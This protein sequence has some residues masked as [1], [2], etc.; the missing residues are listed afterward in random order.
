MASTMHDMLQLKGMH[1]LMLVLVSL[2]LAMSKFVNS[3]WRS[4][5]SKSD[6]AIIPLVLR[7]PKR[8]TV[9]MF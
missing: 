8:M 3:E 7:C 5:I 9:I 2:S 4:K 6:Y 1:Y